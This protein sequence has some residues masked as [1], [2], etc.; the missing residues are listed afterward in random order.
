MSVERHELTL[1]F[2]L[3]DARKVKRLD[4]HCLIFVTLRPPLSGHHS[5][6]PYYIPP[7]FLIY[8]GMTS[9]FAFASDPI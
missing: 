8:E 9:S 5:S 1:S 4:D 7:F 2:N 3:D 6:S